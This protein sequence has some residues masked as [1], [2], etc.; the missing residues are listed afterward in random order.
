MDARV[1][2]VVACIMLAAMATA[3]LIHQFLPSYE[4]FVFRRT[5]A[6]LAVKRMLAGLRRPF[7]ADARR[8]GRYARAMVDLETATEFR[9]GLERRMAADLGP[10]GVAAMRETA[11]FALVERHLERK[12]ARAA[13]YLGAMTD[14]DVRRV[15]DHYRRGALEG[16]VGLDD[17]ESFFREERE[18]VRASPHL[19]S[20]HFSRMEHRFQRLHDEALARPGKTV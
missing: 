1:V 8:L 16:K 14:A 17:V 12:R 4:A 13:R 11:T 6:W 15:A 3:A 2:P 18:L 7:D 19:A 10:E 20:G 5:F 9:D